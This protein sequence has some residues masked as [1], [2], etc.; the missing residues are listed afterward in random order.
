MSG[1]M[2][3]SVR[4]NNKINSNRNILHVHR[5][6][7]RIFDVL[8]IITIVCLFFLRPGGEKEEDHC[9]GAVSV[10]LQTFSSYI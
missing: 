5:F 4:Y 1:L 3:P 2:Y 9:L 8:F 7:T 6:F 10:T